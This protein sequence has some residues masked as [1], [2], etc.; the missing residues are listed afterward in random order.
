MRPKF[1]Q[2]ARLY[3]TGKTYK[4]NDLDEIKVDKTYDAKKVIGEYLKP[5]A[6]N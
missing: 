2:P 1:N 6:F 4:F 5:L 3:G